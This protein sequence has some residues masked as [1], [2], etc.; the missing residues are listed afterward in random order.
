MAADT[1]ANQFMNRFDANKDGQ[2]TAAEWLAI[3]K[4]THKKS[5]DELE[6][7]VVKLCVQP[8]HRLA[9]ALCS[10]QSS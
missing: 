5:V 8:N 6:K 10:P 7:L 1:A 2:I 9:A 3:C 4:N